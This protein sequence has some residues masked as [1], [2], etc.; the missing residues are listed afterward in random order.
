MIWCR[1]GSDSIGSCK[2]KHHVLILDATHLRSVGK[3]SH[4][5]PS[6]GSGY[7]VP[8]CCRG[9]SGLSIRL[10]T[11]WCVAGPTWPTRCRISQIFVRISHVHLGKREL[12]TLGR[13]RHLKK[14]LGRWLD[15]SSHASVYARL[16]VCSKG[17]TWRASPPGGS[18]DAPLCLTKPFSKVS[19]V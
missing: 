2:K 7:I 9:Q 5:R 1:R 4:L 3:N 18:R 11:V 16:P 14:I 8:T 19:Q 13:G 10:N 15:G 12:K 6:E 17:N